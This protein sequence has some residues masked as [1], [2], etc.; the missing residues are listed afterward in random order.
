MESSQA[1]TAKPP[2]L[3]LSHHYSTIT[4]LRQPSDLKKFYKFFQIP[5]IGNLAGGLP[6]P[7][8]FPYDTLEAQAAKPERWTPTPNE[9]PSP[10]AV[11]DT[12]AA[13]TISSAPNGG[14][15]YTDKSSGPSPESEKKSWG[16]NLFGSQKK[17]PRD[18]DDH[19]N[20][21]SAN[22]ISIPKVRPDADLSKRIDLATALQYGTA[23]GYPPLL[24]FIRHFTRNHLH[25]DVPYAGGPEV[26]LSC[27]S[28]D[29]M[30]KTLELLTDP[31][32][33]A[34]DAIASRPHLL[35]EKFLYPNVL[36][37]SRPRGIGIVPVEIDDEGMLVDGPGGLAAVLASWDDRRG[38]RPHL[39]Y[40][41]TMGH[42]PTSGVLSVKRRREIYALCQKYDIIIIEDDPYWFLQYPSAETEEAVSRGQTV[43]VEKHQSEK[44]SSYTPTKSSGYPFLDSLVP[45][46]LSM[47]V[48]GRVV[49]LDTFSKTIAPGCR[50]GWVTAQPEFIERI[51]RIA[52]TSTQQPSG[53][54]QAMVSELLLGSQPP[55][56]TASF[57]S[58]PSKKEQLAFEGWDTSGWVRWLEGLRGTYERRMS[59]MARILD[60]GA[61][62][63]QLKQPVRSKPTGQDDTRG[64]KTDDDW[65][66]VTKTQLYDF[67][68]PRGGMFVWLRIRFPSHPLWMARG[69]PG[70]SLPRVDGLALG[71]AL[72]AFCTHRP[73]LVLPAPGAMFAADEVV[74]ARDAWAYYRLC[75]AAESEEN[76]DAASR[77]FVD[78]LHAFWRIKDVERIEELVEEFRSAGVEGGLAVEGMGN[79]AGADY[80]C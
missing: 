27:G 71:T 56:I 65:R 78:A 13:A 25:P 47:D 80:A 58:L 48:D 1:T 59:R 40:T 50:L 60:D 49:R 64:D 15:R 45:S 73:H 30:A 36:A 31:W 46:Y 18:D 29:G 20:P 61:H 35:V 69:A 28:T 54:V 11:A 21:K 2:P 26:V 52:E 37:Q 34:T 3:D 38:R 75:F 16:L 10:D 23:E 77:R 42:N 51:V 66:V 74:L 39:M 4:K 44:D 63:L 24:S 76:V 32:N 9:P 79:L 70:G 67:A 41:V 53:F 12:M 33:P 19:N 17:S 43:P 7:S 68:W 8:F 5:G 6:N 14:S 72:L 57:A 22:H 62:L 55:S